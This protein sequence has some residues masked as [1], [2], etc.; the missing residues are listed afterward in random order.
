MMP[1]YLE[2]GLLTR[3]PF[4]TI[5]Q[6]AWA[7]SCRI[8]A[9]RGRGRKPDLKLGRVRRARRRPR[10]DRASST[11]SGSTT[12]RARRSGCR[13]PGWRRRRPCSPAERPSPHTVTPDVATWQWAT[14][15]A[16]V[17][18]LLLV[19]LLVVQR[20]PHAPPL[21]EALIES[22]AWIAVSLAFGLVVWDWFGSAVAGQY[23]TAYLLEKSLSVDNVFVW[24]LI[25]TRFAVPVAYRR[26]GAVL[27]RVRRA[28][29]CGRS[30]SPPASGC[31][32]G[33]RRCSTSSAPSW[34]SP[35]C[36]CSPA[37]RGPPTRPRGARRAWCSAS[38]PR[39]T[40]TTARAS[41]PRP[42]GRRVA[43]P[44]FTVLVLVEV[45]DLVFATDSIPA[46]L[47]GHPQHVRGVQLERLR[48]VR[49][50]GACTSAWRGPGPGSRTSTKGWRR[51]CSSWA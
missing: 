17:V 16:L 46:V 21:R 8:G 30:A 13:S 51:C 10:V 25:L 45:T 29:R 7:S 9:E 14:F 34:W 50:A 22:A 32:T 5:D 36:G 19:E 6:T 44:L 20:R 41:S 48:G 24:A 47:V 49:P 40:A 1:A 4:E 31:S 43:T 18:G 12:C 15:L 3:N 39:P 37:T 28:R 23:Y 33:S 38:C 42:A 26:A 35:R 27:G 2:E 11:T